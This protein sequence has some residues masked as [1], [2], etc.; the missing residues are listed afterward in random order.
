MSDATNFDDTLDDLL[1]DAPA[2][3]SIIQDHAA[4]A[5]VVE[6]PAP[7]RRRKT[8][9]PVEP[10]V[11]AGPTI[12]EPALKVQT[13]IEDFV[14]ET[15]APQV[16]VE[17]ATEAEPADPYAHLSPRQRAQLEAEQNMGRHALATGRRI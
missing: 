14:P 1:G 13:T 3:P 11:I 7:K 16:T 15:P 9:E 6:A 4:D 8:T 2:A 10:E 17:I 5:A 12:E